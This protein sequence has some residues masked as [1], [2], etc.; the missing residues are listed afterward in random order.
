MVFV[1]YPPSA[2]L[3]A[4]R[5]EKAVVYRAIA[6][7]YTVTGSTS[8]AAIPQGGDSRATHPGASAG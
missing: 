5:G 6:D 4:A 2:P 3:I 8:Q 7:R 1:R